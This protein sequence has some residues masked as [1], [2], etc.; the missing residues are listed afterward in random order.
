MHSLGEI[1]VKWASYPGMTLSACLPGN[2]RSSGRATDLKS[3]NPEVRGQGQGHIVP[4]KWNIIFGARF[5][6]S[7]TD[8]WD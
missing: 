5:D 7:M 1:S 2:A 6:H 4:S 3:L 8:V